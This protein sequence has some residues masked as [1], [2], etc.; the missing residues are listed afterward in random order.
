MT[1]ISSKDSAHDLIVKFS[2]STC[3]A[4]LALLTREVAFRSLLTVPV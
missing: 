3:G 1:L 2:L 4:A